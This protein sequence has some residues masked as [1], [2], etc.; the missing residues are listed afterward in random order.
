VTVH[1]EKKYTTSVPFDVERRVRRLLKSVPAD[2][3]IGL[4]EITIV[5]RVTHAK[6]K[7]SGGLYWQRQGREPARIEIGISAV[8]RGVPRV[9]LYLP[10][11]VDFILA[12]VL[13]HEIGH[14][15]QQ[16]VHGIGKK[17]AEAFADKYR[18][19]RI[20]KAFFWWLIILAPFSPLIH[21]L[22]R[23]ANKKRGL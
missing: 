19:E 16:S 22:R 21:W 20:G 18:K 8:Y 17:A 23:L 2:H 15:H 13:Y 10:P 5:D 4:D 3:L 12:N 9:V 14:H 1:V 11:V 6:D 7:E